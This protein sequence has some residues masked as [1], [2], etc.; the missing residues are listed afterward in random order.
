MNRLRTAIIAIAVPLFVGSCASYNAH[1]K[2]QEAERLKNWDEAVVQYE[3]ALEL[4][5]DSLRLKIDLQRAKLEASRV[6][7][8][9]GKTL[10]AAADAATGE[11]QVRLAQ[12]AATE[13]QLTV[14]LDPTNQYAAVEMSKV[15]Q[16]PPAPHRPAAHTPTPEKKKR[17]TTRPQPRVLTPAS[18]Q[19]ITLSF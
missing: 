12:L 14:K 7:F 2:A 15:I 3:K 1:Q 10:R 16:I 6:H 19:P 11:E 8:E 17:A 13:L 4:N 18:N 9:K 5:P